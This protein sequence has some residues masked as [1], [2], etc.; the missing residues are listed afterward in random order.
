MTKRILQ[1]DGLYGELNSKRSVDYIFSELIAT[2]SKNFNWVIKPHIHTHLYQLFLIES[3]N[4][5]FHDSLQERK[6]KGPCI[7][8]IPPSVLHGLTYSPNIKGRI[9]TISDS[10]VQNILPDNSE[11]MISIGNLQLITEF[12]AAHSFKLA[13]HLIL[14][15]DK[16][17]FSDY[18]AKRF[19]LNACLTRLFI[20]IHRMLRSGNEVEKNENP[21][22]GHFRRFQKLVMAVNNKK[23]IALFAK[24]LNLSPIHL[25]RVCQNVAGKTAIQV[26]QENIIQEAQKH[27]TYTSRS[28]SEI[29]YL[30]KFEYPNYFAKVFKEHTGYSPKE[31]R[32]RLKRT[33]FN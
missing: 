7:I 3:G 12:E 5:L 14:E 26:V 4:V 25:N 22:L 24:E 17:L 30:L 16:E 1:Y 9:L 31:F 6:L 28:V 15:I 10:F 19:M 32:A 29:A 11:A 23:S 21:S 18:A 13:R 8:F 27:L 2:R 33:G 20:L